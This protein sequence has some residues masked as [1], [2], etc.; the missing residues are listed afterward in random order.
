MEK[1]SI[2]EV[3][4][5]RY[6]E[7]AERTVHEN[8]LRRDRHDGRMPL[9]FFIWI[10]RNQKRTIVVDTGFGERVM[11]TR[12]RPLL[13]HPVEALR[14]IGIVPEAVEHIVLT[15]LHYDHAG[16]LDAFPN[17]TIHVQ[18]KE[19]AFATGRC[20]CH[21]IM[22]HPYEVDDVVEVVRRTYADRTRFHDGDAVIF[23]GISVHL[24]A[25]HSRGLQGVRVRTA[26]GHVLL[27][28]DASHYYENFK[29]GN[30]FP[31]IENTEAALESHQR[32]YE[33]ADS[34]DHIIPGHD[35]LV[36]RLYPRMEIDGVELYALHEPPLQ[37]G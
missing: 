21:Q 30:P 5:L 35:P 3:L 13:V 27:A 17:A 20:M 26:R 8:L 18:D 10:V 6:G 25:G 33:L 7:I 15:H 23:D 14:R 32:Q 28:S 24:L 9:D 12:Q 16:N 19:V 29:R 37:N 36:R 4:A 34:P 22:R 2:Y 31:L 11:R 1:D